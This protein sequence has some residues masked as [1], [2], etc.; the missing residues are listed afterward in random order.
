MF[1]GSSAMNGT[2][3]QAALDAALAYARRGLRVL[4]VHGVRDGRCTCGRPDCAAPGKHPRTPH[5]VREATTD[6]ATIRAWWR[7]WPDANLAV[8]TGSGVIVLDADGPEGVA[9]L[10]ALG[11][12][13]WDGSGG[14]WVARTG[15][16][17]LHVWLA[18]NGHG[19][20]P[21]RNR[22]LPGLDVRGEG[23]YV[24]APPSVHVSGRVYEWLTPPERMPLAEVPS[25]VLLLVAGPNGQAE[26]REAG[27]PIREGERNATLFR[28]GR[29]LALRGLSPDAIAA[30]LSAENAARC[31]PPLPEAEVERIA[32][33]VSA[34]K[35]RREFKLPDA[36]TDDE[37][38]RW[39]AWRRARRPIRC[40][41]TPEP[42]AGRAARFVRLADVAPET[43]RW[44]WSGYL[45]AGKLVLLIGDPGTGKSCVMLDLVARVSRGGQWPDGSPAPRGSALILTAEDGLADTVRPRLDALGGD[46][47]RVYAL[48]SVLAGGREQPFSLA[49]DLDTL[50]RAIAETGAVLV[51]IDPLSAYLGQRIDSFK[52]DQVRSVLGPV[53]ALAER[54]GVTI[55]GIL[56]LTKDAERRA[57]YRALGSVA[58]TAAPRAVF[59][60]GEHPDEP[61][62]RLLVPV[63]A[64]L[65]RKPPV[66]GFRLREAGSAVVVEWDAEPVE[67][68][69]ADAVLSGAGAE[70]RDERRDAEGFLLDLLGEGDVVKASDVFRA[71]RQ[72]GISERTL[73][74]AKRKLGVESSHEG[75]PGQA[76]TWYWWLPPKAATEAPKAAT[77]GNLA[78]F[79]QPGEEKDE[80]AL[81]SPKAA[82]SPP[83][84]AFEQP[85]GSL[86][87]RQAAVQSGSA[88]HDP[89]TAEQDPAGGG[90]EQ[91]CPGCRGAGRGRGYHRL[92]AHGPGI[93]DL[94]PARPG[95]AGAR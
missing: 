9:S 66:L 43:V 56:H 62:R 13:A 8:A 55:V 23:G 48:R 2:V 77:A 91:W 54:T 39:A 24:V 75:Q 3:D 94:P 20:V 34:Q 74:R 64:N 80:S 44:L 92:V 45:P 72:A 37:A 33:S 46:P 29:S 60:V 30:A 1:D 84:A 12:L 38:E 90:A 93:P 35:H 36:V 4:P 21:N 57:I 40:R 61:E 88:E 10:Q 41:P 50:E 53:A 76:G 42:I 95:R 47:R 7:R 79:E 59:A 15:S 25:Q 52:D 32:R 69:D 6:E 82:T 49:R 22:V 70:D 71:A 73:R 89:P 58:F 18:T 85:G 83:L 28:L 31:T 19:A 63:K 68:L 16:G 11:L 26:A 86:R 87:E 27:A 5:G 67:G 14:P 81:T 17:G 78:A 51:G 65:A